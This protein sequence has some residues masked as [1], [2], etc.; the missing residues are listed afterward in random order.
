MNIFCMHGLLLE[1]NIVFL[2]IEYRTI[3]IHFFKIQNVKQ[4]AFIAIYYLGVSKN[5]LFLCVSL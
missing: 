3:A 2:L 5:T 1:L 4:N